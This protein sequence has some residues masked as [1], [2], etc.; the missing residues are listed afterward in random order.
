VASRPFVEG[1]E[2]R[3]VMS[4]APIDKVVGALATDFYVAGGEKIGLAPRADEL[5]VK[6]AA[7]ANAEQVESLL[8]AR[9]GPLSGYSLSRTLGD[10]ILVFARQPVFGPQP[11][12]RSG[13]VDAVGDVSER[14]DGAPGVEWTSPVYNVGGEGTWAV[15]TGEVIV[16]LKPGVT[17]DAFFAGDN[18][19]VSVRPLDGTPDQFVATVAGDGEAAVRISS[20]LSTDARLSWSN[21]NFFREFV[22]NAIPND[23]YYG[24]QWHLNN[25]GQAIGNPGTT[26]GTPGEDIDAQRAWDLT[27]GSSTIVVS[28]VDDGMH[29]T[30]RTGTPY[31]AHPDLVDNLYTNPNEV[32][33]NNIDDDGNGWVDDFRGWDFTTNGA[34]G[35]NDPGAD[36]VNDFHS[37]SVAGVIAARGNNGLGVAG[38]AWTA[39]ILPVRIFGSTGS[40]T[41]D[42]NIASAVY[43]AAGRNRTGNGQ[44]ANVHVMNNSWGGGGLPQ[45]L[46]DAFTW[47]SNTARGGLGTATFISSGNG[48]GA[49]SNPAVLAGTLGG[50][51]AVGAVDRNGVRSS[52][53]AFGPSLSFT[54]P[55]NP[56]SSDYDI[57]TTDG[58]GATGWNTGPGISGNDDD[59]FPD[60]DYTSV[61]GGTSTA[62]PVSAGVGVLI[63]SRAQA[64]GVTL[65]SADVKKLMLNTTELV[66]PT[67]VVYDAVTGRNDLYGTGRVNAFNAV[68]GINAREI[69]V[70]DGRVSIVDG[71]S[72]IAMGSLRTG[73]DTAT[74]TIRIRNEG[75]LD[76]NLSSLAISG[77]SSFSIQSGFTDNVLSIGETATFVVRFAPTVNGPQTATVSFTSNDSDEGSFD[78]TLSGVGTPV[79]ISGRVIEDWNAD[80]MADPGEPGLANRLVYIDANNNAMFDTETFS[81]ASGAI[82]LPIPD[83]NPTGVSSTLPVAGRVGTIADLNVNLSA[84]HTW[85]SDLT[86]RL[87][88]PNNQVINLIA[89]RGGSTDNFVNTTLDDQAATA[90]SGG[91]APFTGSFRPEQPLSTFNG[92]SPNGNWTLIVSDS[93]SGD[94]GVLQNWSMTIVTTT[95][96][97]TTTDA[98]GGY[99]FL[100]LSAGTYNV[101]QLAATGWF[102]TGPASHVVSL[103][104]ADSTAPGRNFGQVRANAIYG[105]IYNDADSSFSRGPGEAGLPGRTAFLDA[106]NNGS[107]NVGAVVVGSGAINLGIPDNNVTGVSSTL[108]V[109]GVAGTVTDVNVTVNITHTFVGD[110]IL[111]LTGPNNQVIT[112]INRRGGGGDNFTATTL[113]DQA[114]TSVTTGVAPFT[115][116]FRPEQALST[117]NGINPNG[118]WRLNVSDRAGA[119]V[120]SLMN[121][122]IQVTGVGDIAA[123][124]DSFGN[125]RIDGV[126][127]GS[128]FVRQVVPPGFK[129]T[130]PQGPGGFYSGTQVGGSP[131]LGA[132]FGTAE[133]TPPTVVSIVRADTTPTNA[134]TVSWTVT[135]SEP[136]IGVG[137][138]GFSLVAGAGLS[139]A[140]IT[141]V[142]GTGATRIVTASTGAGQGTLGL[143]IAAPGTITDIA[144]NQL[145]GTPVSGQS[146]AIDKV[147][148]SVSQFRLLY[149]TSGSHDLLSGPRVNVPWAITGV[150]VVFSE[151][152]NGSITA[153][154]RTNGAMPIASHSG[155][156]TTSHTWNFVSP[157][158]MAV[159]ITR[160][161]AGQIGDALGNL[162]AVD[163][164]R[165]FNAL[166]G[167][168]NGDGV[169]STT[170]LVLVRNKA[171]MAY[172]PFA[173][174]NGDGVVNGADA[175]LVRSR[176]ARRLP[177]A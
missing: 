148:P 22:K 66:G 59:P 119:D 106:D 147:A 127:N 118:A 12:A 1:L 165:N 19:F 56:S 172:D 32:P 105:S 110:L 113:D 42:A 132:N 23:T 150:Q 85:N 124:T 20:Q 43:Y 152:T 151:A 18:R 140:V 145:A 17:A 149:G 57:M 89:A 130:Q 83:A 162:L 128:L 70:F 67:N 49:V 137:I 15:P 3:L 146:Y 24:N 79:S 116:S 31:L 174:I 91:V 88:G 81:V 139:G 26:G 107:F 167:D 76:L 125:Y 16:A 117:F 114:A 90:I 41:T 108:N 36:S 175:N 74:R 161:K 5:A 135:F 58:P 61:F 156:G 4:T 154:E 87:R 11:L 72:N 78:F 37:T 101:R 62:S 82:N 163:Y 33:G 45:A 123:T 170:D 54:A 155:N 46:I 92:I 141:S 109:A 171:A 21:P 111:T 8:L 29:I 44:W 94:T 25:T 168:F 133:A 64:L 65:T 176:L 120:G 138:G 14:V 10:S 71:S 27:T 169:V 99:A 166:E 159:V 53:S 177:P 28:V 60:L 47:S 38:V 50:V 121:W 157:M 144:L 126:P 103:A 164:G 75:T 96:V 2:A 84:T 52:Y 6:V 80:G 68:S 153:F 158:D 48:G 115:G 9:G 100:G 122:S 7:G 86:F 134:S 34:N 129:Q 39:K 98:G 102:L 40:A 160:L 143:N 13:R 112:L 93:T 73:I 95:E 30:T 55:S 173:D 136:V 104:T 142:T 35:D 63:M 97:S 131:N 69:G 51:M 77:A